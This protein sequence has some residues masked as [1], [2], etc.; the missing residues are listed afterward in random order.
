VHGRIRLEYLSSANTVTFEQLIAQQRSHF[1]R[2][3]QDL[4]RRHHLAPQEIEELRIVVDRALERNNYELLR[5]FDGRSTWET[6]LS[7]VV[8]RLFFEF[9]GDMWGPWRPTPRASRLG[10]AGILL[11]E[12][13]VRDGLA[14]PE[15][16]HV[17]RTT[18]RV[19]VPQARL[20]Q[21]AAQL[22]LHAE[23]ARAANAT[24][25][26]SSQT[27]DV[28]S[29]L[30]DAMALLLP[31]DRLI[32]A[33]RF[34]D[35]QPLTRIA[36]VMKIDARPLQRRIDQAKEVIRT[37]LQMQGVAADD[38]EVVLEQAEADAHTVKRTWWTTVRSRAS[39]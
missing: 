7:T 20:E 4:A 17:M 25:E 2:V 15:A 5:A 28:Q 11:E 23:H 38:I 35:G 19:D 6:Y 31:D 34:G 24:R 26:T 22:E 27:V 30:R 12:L 16:I 18:H 21:M 1:G 32:L 10:P 37:S 29:A 14:I 39:R 33:M 36:K 9:Q 8:T 13:V 3:V